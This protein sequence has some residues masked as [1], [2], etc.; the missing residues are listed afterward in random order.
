MRPHGI[1]HPGIT[2]ACRAAQ[3]NG[4]DLE[5]VLD[6]SRHSSIETLM[7]Y[8]DRERDIRDRLAQLFADVQ[9]TT[10]NIGHL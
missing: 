2:K 8:R 5:E 3:A 1:R 10:E 9:K 6:F 4:I 7:I